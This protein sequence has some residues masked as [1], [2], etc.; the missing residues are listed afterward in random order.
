[1]DL[2]VNN[3][4]AYRTKEILCLKKRNEMKLLIVCS[5]F[6]NVTVLRCVIRLKGFRTPK[7]L[8]LYRN[9]GAG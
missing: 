5:I 6:E 1:M 2:F 4:R 9:T 7:L 8:V 3:D